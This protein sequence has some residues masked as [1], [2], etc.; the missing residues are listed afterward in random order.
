VAQGLYY[1]GDMGRK[2]V[3]SY[4]YPEEQA[5]M[6]AITSQEYKDTEHA[7]IIIIYDIVMKKVLTHFRAHSQPL[8][9]IAFD[10][11]GTLLVTASI[12]GH[13]FNVFQICPPPSLFSRDSTETTPSYRHLYKLVRGVTNATIQD[14]SFSSDSKWMAVSSTRGTT[15]ITLP[16]QN[17]EFIQAHLL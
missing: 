7:G 1:L 10:P 11:T 4:L 12:G 6:Q 15:R 8:S 2:T 14:I 16:T 3:S 9:T 13:N 5:P 17:S